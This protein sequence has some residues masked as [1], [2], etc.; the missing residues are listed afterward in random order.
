MIRE[1][2]GGTL[3][4]FPHDWALLLSWC[5][6]S[7]HRTSR[8][9]LDEPKIGSSSVYILWWDSTF[10]PWAKSPLTAVTK[11]VDEWIIWISFE[12][13]AL[14]LNKHTCTDSIQYDRRA[15]AIRNIDDGRFHDSLSCI[16]YSLCLVRT[17]CYEYTEALEHWF[18]FLFIEVLRFLGLRSKILRHSTHLQHKYTLTKKDLFKTFSHGTRK[19]PVH[20]LAF[21]SRPRFFHGV[22]S[23]SVLKVK[24]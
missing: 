23:V 5:T 6:Y 21:F 12:C 9:T 22:F 8:C 14:E 20:N 19:I 15:V 2:G 10:P 16:V 1:F 4:P 3:Y 7:R 17:P 11:V 13:L 24:F 18:I